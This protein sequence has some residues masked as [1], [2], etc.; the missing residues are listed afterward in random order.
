MASLDP[1]RF[2]LVHASGSASTAPIAFWEH[3]LGDLAECVRGARNSLRQL[4]L[5]FPGDLSDTSRATPFP[6]TAAVPD[7]IVMKLLP[8]LLLA[9]APALTLGTLFQEG[10][11]QS[12]GNNPP[13]TEDDDKRDQGAGS[14][15]IF[16]RRTL[17][18]RN[19]LADQLIGGW[20]LR[21][22]D[23]SGVSSVGR[24]AQGFLN[25]NDAYLSMEIHAAYDEKS[26]LDAPP[27]DVHTTF[28]A[29]YRLIGGNSI[30]CLTVI[31]SFLDDQTGELRWERAGFS[32]RYSVEQ[33]AGQLILTYGEEFGEVTRL[34]FVPQLPRVK[35]SRDIFG[36]KE[37]T[38]TFGSERDIFGSPKAGGSGE[39]DIFGRQ[40][41][42]TD[43]KEKKEGDN[44]GKSLPGSTPPAGATGRGGSR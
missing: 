24:I 29:E 32:R 26:G 4:T 13:A 8:S 39:R 20:R 41:P 36:R 25:I 18:R 43:P 30:E 3:L 9:A 14:L 44:K 34:V 27:T 33:N 12:G 23:L 1:S 38:G 16:G 37:G 22:L 11:P 15:D 19:S 10:T 28:T 40:K 31:G 2:E 5:G 7:P 42:P 21:Q 35:G 6:W 17:A